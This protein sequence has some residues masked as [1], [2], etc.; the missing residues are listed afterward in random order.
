M[1]RRLE[2]SSGDGASVSSDEL[3]AWLDGNAPACAAWSL[4]GERTTLGALYPEEEAAVERA[5]PVRRRDFQAG[6][7]CAR[8][9]LRALGHEAVALPAGVDRMP[10]WPEP[11]VG[12]IAHTRSPEAVAVAVGARSPSVL[13]L[14]VDVEERGGTRQLD[15]ALIAT[16]EECLAS[17]SVVGNG[18][19]LDVLFSVKEAGYKALYPVNRRFLDFLDVEATFRGNEFELRMLQP[20]GADRCTVLKGRWGTVRGWTVALA[21]VPA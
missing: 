1:I 19:Y 15:A 3:A 9:V 11:I 20:A 7:H 21:W 5:V 12:S 8:E 17:I 13:S 16:R 10:V 4:A 6:R 2:S 14:G 18:G